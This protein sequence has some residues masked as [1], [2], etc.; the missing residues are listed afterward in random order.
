MQRAKQ[1]NSLQK[2]NKE[3]IKSRDKAKE[4]SNKLRAKN[5][6]LEERIAALEY[7]LKKN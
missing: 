5:E 1:L 7:E 6:R 4:K 2:R 3:L